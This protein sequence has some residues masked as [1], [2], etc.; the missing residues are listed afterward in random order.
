[1]KYDITYSCG[2]AGTVEL[3]GKTSER[4]S[5]IRWYETTAVCPECYKKQ[6]AE[7][8]TKQK[9]AYE[10]PELEG[11]EKQVAWAKK[12]MESAITVLE[13][14]GRKTAEEQAPTEAAK[15]QA[16]KAIDAHI[17]RIRSAKHA[18]D[19]IDTFKGINFSATSKSDILGKI[20][21]EMDYN[22]VSPCK[23]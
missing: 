19:I 9:A 1:M 10:L 12:L 22:K 8:T 3:Y 6:Q 2:H 23:F 21:Y 11:S 16:H 13:T 15:S 20:F 4:E 18:A 7:T 14:E 5:K 17:A